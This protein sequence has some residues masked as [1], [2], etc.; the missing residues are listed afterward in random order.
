M[1]SS[2]LANIYLRP[3]DELLEATDVEYLRYTDDLWVFTDTFA[4]ARR[5]QDMIERHLYAIGLTLTGEKTVIRKRE[6]AVD[7][8]RRSTAVFQERRDAIQQEAVAMFEDP[9]FDPEDLPEPGAID[10]MA[11]M[12]LYNEA[13]GGLD[14]ESIPRGTKS[15]LREVYWKLRKARAAN[16]IADVPRVLVRLPDLTAEGMLYVA[17]AAQNDRDAAL[18]AFEEVVG[19]D[20]F[21]R[22]YER[23][24]IC[25]AALFLPPHA[26][27]ELARAFA[28]WAENDDHQL[29]RARA[30]LAWGAQGSEGDFAV[31][32][33]F[34]ETAARSWRIYAFVAIQDRIADQRDLR[35]L[36]WSSAGGPLE[37]LGREIRANRFSWR[38]I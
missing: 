4:E 21:H 23:L 31:A 37:R 19:G 33:R 22:E 13:I 30:L 24:Q 7:R 25:R 1:A 27:D 14:E 34:W 12:D 3:L 17:F 32:D 35:Y 20:R 26:S 6:H 38:R 36:R 8:V 18:T 28:G 5:L 15:T 29:V 9:Y 11:A 2:P 16:V 10:V